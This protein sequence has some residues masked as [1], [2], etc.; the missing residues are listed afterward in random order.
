MSLRVPK[1][2][3]SYLPIQFQSPVYL[4]YSAFTSCT[5]PTNAPTFSKL[6]TKSK[7]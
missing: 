1:M 5:A 7:G 3:V 2:K 4:H 6:I